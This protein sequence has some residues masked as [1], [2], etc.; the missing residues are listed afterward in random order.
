MSVHTQH[1]P[2]HQ[3]VQQIPQQP[4]SQQLRDIPSQPLPGNPYN[5]NVPSNLSNY[6]SSNQMSNDHQSLQGQDANIGQAVLNLMY[7]L[8][9]SSHLATAAMIFTRGTARTAAREN[10]DAIMAVQ[11]PD[12]GEMIT[13]GLDLNIDE[14]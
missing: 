10:V 5:P 1:A 2:Q 11:R 3:V 8:T 4:M 6:T 9:N 12:T 14:N 7:Q 13:S